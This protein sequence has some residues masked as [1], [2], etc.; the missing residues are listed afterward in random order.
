MLEYKIKNL[1]NK[2]KANVQRLWGEME[3]EDV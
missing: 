2:N 1:K 3:K